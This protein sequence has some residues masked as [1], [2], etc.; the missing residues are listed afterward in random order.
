MKQAVKRLSIL[1][2]ALIFGAFGSNVFGQDLVEVFDGLGE[3]FLVSQVSHEDTAFVKN[4][5]KKEEAAVN[6]K[7]E[8]VLPPRCEVIPRMRNVLKGT[9]T[10]PNSSQKAYFYQIDCE[11]VT[12]HSSYAYGIMIAE[13][14]KVIFN[15]YL[16]GSYG[17]TIRVLP[18][19][20]QNNV[21]E[22]VFISESDP[23]MTNHSGSTTMSIV[24]LQSNNNFNFLGD[25]V[26]NSWTDFDLNG[27]TRPFAYRI[28]VKPTADPIFFRE[29][30]RRENKWEL[31]KELAEFKLDKRFF[32]LERKFL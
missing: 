4:A 16:E 3:F 5:L 28:F 12:I 25:T 29:T 18:D 17:T 1:V 32:E 22:I 7:F 27:D 10:V 2:F 19:I 30:Y 14:N 24:E 9:F 11:Q 31:T 26:V 6:K 20:N 15:R 21:S 23:A 13:N 8:T